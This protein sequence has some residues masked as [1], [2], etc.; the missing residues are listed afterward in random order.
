MYSRKLIKK[1]LNLYPPVASLAL[2]DLKKRYGESYLG[3]FWTL[4]EPLGIITVYSLVFPL[5][6]HMDF[7]QWVIY[8][9][10]GLLPFRYFSDGITRVTNSLLDNRN[11]LNH[12][13]IPPIVVP[14]AV[15]LANGISFLLECIILIFIILLLGVVPNILVVAFPL[16]FAIETLLVLGVGLYLSRKFTK[17]RDLTHILRVF[18]EALFFLT[19]IVYRLNLIPTD[20]H[21]IYLLNPVTHLILLYQSIFAYPLANFVPQINFWGSMVLLLAFAGSVFVVGWWSFRQ[22]DRK[23]IERL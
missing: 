17:Y 3:F 16:V 13:N 23:V 8:F 15:G 5:I 18:F 11:L 1:I 4:L 9:V 20:F 2:K 22:A 7:Y 12:L 14:L 21:Q 10:A 19:P 6:L